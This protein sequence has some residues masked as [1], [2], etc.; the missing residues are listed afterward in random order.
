MIQRN[1]S[2]E[3]EI[4][5]VIFK[6]Q[7]DI[8]CLRL[9]KRLLNIREKKS[10]CFIFILLIYFKYLGAVFI[11]ENLNSIEYSH[12]TNVKVVYVNIL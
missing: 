4:H 3:T 12:I 6:P 7:T 1:V 10:N 2:D 11:V 8:H 5:I 9:V